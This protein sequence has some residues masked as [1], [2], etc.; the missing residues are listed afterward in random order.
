ASI[1]AQTEEELA[2]LGEAAGLPQANLVTIIGRIIKIILSSL[3][4]VAVVLIIYAGFTWITAGGVPE[5]INKAKKIIIGAVI[6]LVIIVSSYAIAS[7]I[8]NKLGEA[9]GIEGGI[10]VGGPSGEGG[11]SGLPRCSCPPRSEAPY[12]C[13]ISPSSGPVGKYVTIWGCRF[14]EYEEGKSKIKFG[15]EES[16]IAMCGNKPSWKDTKIVTIVP[17]GLEIDTF[18]SIIVVSNKEL[19]SINSKRFKVTSGVPGPGIACVVPDIGKQG[20]SVDIFGDRFGDSQGENE[21]AFAKIKAEQINSWE[22]KKINATI[23]DGAISGNIITTVDGIE[24]NGYPFHVKCDLADDCKRDTYCCDGLCDTMVCTNIDGSC[25]GGKKCPLGYSCCS[26]EICRRDCNTD[27]TCV[28]DLPCPEGYNCCEDKVCRINCEQALSLCN[29]NGVQDA[30][31]TGI[32][33]GSDVCPPCGSLGTTCYVS[34]GVCGEDNLCQ[35]STSQCKSEEDECRCCCRDDGGC[36]EGLICDQTQICAGKVHGLC[37]G[38]EKA[39]QCNK[40]ETCIAG[41]CRTCQGEPDG[42][43]CNGGVCCSGVC[44]RGDCQDGLCIPFC[45]NGKIDPGEQCDGND[46]GEQTCESLGFA[47]GTLVC[48]YNCTF[49]TRGCIG[50]QSG[51]LGDVCI[52][53]EIEGCASGA[54]D[55]AAGGPSVACVQNNPNA[56]CACCCRPKEGLI[57]DTCGAG[58]IA[59]CNLVCDTTKPCGKSGQKGICCGCDRDECCNNG[60]GQICVDNCCR[61]FP[62]PTDLIVTGANINQIG[63]KWKDNSDYETG[64]EIYRSLDEKSW[65]LIAETEANITAYVDTEDTNGDEP[66]NFTKDKTYYYRIRAKR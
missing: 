28:G 63:L 16:S 31:E 10:T 49:D 47:R 20:E 29:F 11:L 43:K 5:K 17:D 62:A 60:I 58:A 32:D 33:C 4:I 21:V 46:F 7:F 34:P 66:G 61:P 22:N 15:R 30:G 14:G 39:E 56:P 59:G 41:C 65:K 6:G 27:G 12:I 3:G 13:S 2:E 53:P 23:P 48:S 26:D 45:G 35:L 18:H 44:C 54:A 42:T 24:S 25:A 36:P 55:C 9:A 51:G 38:C 37:C 1:F 40:N 50:A 52:N 64:F 57:P 19:E 8:M